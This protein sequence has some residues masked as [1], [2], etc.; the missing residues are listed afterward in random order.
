MLSRERG[1]GKCPKIHAM[2]GGGEGP[3]RDF[4]LSC[5]PLAL[6]SLPSIFT[7][8]PSS[9]VTGVGFGLE[10]GFGFPKV[11]AKGARGCRLQLSSFPQ[12][13]SQG[14]AL[15]P[16]GCSGPSRCSPQPCLGYSHFSF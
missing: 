11:K 6:H 9:T 16:E 3:G 12:D 8:S 1:E 2:R 10:L 4:W 7:P 5:A 14:W 13:G 15:H